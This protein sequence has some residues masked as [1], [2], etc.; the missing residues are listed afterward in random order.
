MLGVHG[1]A[2]DCGVSVQDAVQDFVLLT[3]S[4]PPDLNLGFEQHAIGSMASDQVS[5][6]AES[7]G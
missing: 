7:V 5:T 1:K 6:W 4:E 3:A 2:L